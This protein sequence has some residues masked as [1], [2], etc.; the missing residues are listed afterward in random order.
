MDHAE[1]LRLSDRLYGLIMERCTRRPTGGLLLDNDGAQWGRLC[2]IVR[3]FH[4]AAVAPRG[5]SVKGGRD[6]WAHW[7]GYVLRTQQVFLSESP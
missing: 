7:C 1:P 5:G 4:D 2:T 6:A 3:A